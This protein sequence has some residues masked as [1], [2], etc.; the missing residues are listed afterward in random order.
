VKV[1]FFT[2]QVT[3]ST[4]ELVTEGS[5][6]IDPGN[7]EPETITLTRGLAT[8]GTV[9]QDAGTFTAT[10]NFPVST[11]FLASVVAQSLTININKAN[12]NLRICPP[13]LVCGQSFSVPIAVEGFYVAPTGNVVVSILSGNTTLQSNSM[14]LT[15]SGTSGIGTTSTFSGLRVGTYKIQ[16]NYAGDA[17]YAA[18][19]SQQVLVVGQAPCKADFAVSSLLGIVGQVLSYKCH[20]LP[21]FSSQPYPTGVCNIVDG[22][23]QI[24]QTSLTDGALINLNLPLLNLGVH[25]L[26][27]GYP[28]DSCYQSCISP[29]QSITINL[30]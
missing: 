13:A 7:G 1:F 14:T 29:L 20:V 24:Q 30:L 17:N 22:S 6:F 19:F 4:G 26:Y 12:P 3:G 2:V 5:V 23:K 18:E 8:Y 15:T 21:I 9:Y 28:G 16:V 11:N 27:C 10:A 25:A